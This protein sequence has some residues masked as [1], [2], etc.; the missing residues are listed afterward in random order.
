MAS[1]FVYLSCLSW[2]CDCFCS[3][4][5]LFVFLLPSW[6]F[7]YH[8]HSSQHGEPNSVVGTLLALSHLILREA[9]WGRSYHYL[10]RGGS[11]R[12][13]RLSNLPEAPALKRWGWAVNPG[14][15]NAINAPWMFVEEWIR[16]LRYRA[17]YLY[18]TSQYSPKRFK[19][20]DCNFKN[21]SYISMLK[22]LAP[23]TCLCSSSHNNFLS[24]FGQVFLSS[25]TDEAPGSESL[26]GSLKSHSEPW[27]RAK[28]RPSSLPPGSLSPPIACGWGGNSFW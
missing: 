5:I 17:I 21:V 1:L 10:H 28:G 11:G 19:E 25:L 15:L 23:N 4:L 6:V 3:V 16:I 7:N 24:Y 9:P 12:T 22:Y 18:L 8:H 13:E 26:C 27:Q 2:D 14:S 20:N